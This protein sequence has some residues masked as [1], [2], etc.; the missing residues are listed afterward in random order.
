MMV[1]I[2]VPVVVS[3]VTKVEVMVVMYMTMA[4]QGDR[5]SMVM[6]SVTKVEVMAVML[7]TII[8]EIVPVVSNVMT[9]MVKIDVVMIPFIRIPMMT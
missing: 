2:E 7:V 6:S 3:S 4:I 9:A 8:V 1:E 5:V